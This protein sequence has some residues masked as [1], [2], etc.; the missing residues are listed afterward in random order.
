MLRRIAEQREKLI[1]AQAERYLD[2]DEPVVHWV[3]ARQ[4][5]GRGEGFVFLTNDRCVVHFT[6]RHEPPGSFEWQEIVSWGVASDA[7]GG[8]VLALETDGGRCLVQLR[9]T[10]SAMAEDVSTFVGH[11]AEMAPWPRRKISGG[12]AFGGF[13]PTSSAPQV[14]AHRMTVTDH[15]RRVIVTVLGLGLIIGAIV[16]IP[17]PG[18]WSFVVTLAGLALLAR[19]YDWARDAMEWTKQRYKQAARKIKARR[20]SDP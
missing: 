2:D 5:E 17:L 9:A 1:L 11:F 20:Q 10:T 13:E 19:E 12:D 18:P 7:K 3:R 6:G 15:S 14:E 16:I 8:P 4:V